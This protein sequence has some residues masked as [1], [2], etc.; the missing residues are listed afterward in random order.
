MHE[1][2]LSTTTVFSGRIVRLETQEVALE[3]GKR[4]YREIVR[5]PGAVCVLLRAPDG[6]FALIRQF[7]KPVEKILLEVVAGILEQGERPDA[8]ARREVN[9]ETGFDTVS[10]RRMGTLFPTPGYVD[11]RIECYYAEA[12]GERAAHDLDEDER[13]EV[14]MLTEDELAARIR[15]GE[16]EDAKTLAAWALYRGG[17]AEG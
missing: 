11:E 1:K 4:A 2:T 12:G 17:A 6:R 16:V 14:V 3:N 8:C 5:H 13:L 10:L 9:E 15:R 7:R